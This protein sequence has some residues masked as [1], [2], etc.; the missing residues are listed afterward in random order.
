MLILVL[1]L[2][3]GIISWLFSRPE[4]QGPL[5]EANLWCFVQQMQRQMQIVD[6][7]WTEGGSVKGDFLNIRAYIRQEDN[8]KFNFEKSNLS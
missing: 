1:H 5:E 8:M 7:G 4:Y 6:G 3:L 2:S